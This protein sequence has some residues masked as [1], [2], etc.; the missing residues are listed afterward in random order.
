MIDVILAFCSPAF[1][2][3]NGYQILA[4]PYKSPPIIFSS[5]FNSGATVQGQEEQ[6]ENIWIT[7]NTWW[8]ITIQ[9]PS[10]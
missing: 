2:L 3:V 7:E 6:K 1:N 10:M 9:R 5:S 8:S 4:D